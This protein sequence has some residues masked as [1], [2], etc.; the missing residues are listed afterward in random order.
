[1]KKEHVACLIAD[2]GLANL[3]LK[4]FDEISDCPEIDLEN[5]VWINSCGLKVKIGEYKPRLV[6]KSDIIDIRFVFDYTNYDH[7]TKA[8]NI[9]ADFHR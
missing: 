3:I 8:F 4:K 2:K 5:E 6:N 7:L 9:T 1:M